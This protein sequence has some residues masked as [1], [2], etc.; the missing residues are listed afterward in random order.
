MGRLFLFGEKHC[1]PHNATS[2][3]AD[4]SVGVMTGEQRTVVEKIQF[5]HSCKTNKMKGD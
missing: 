2:N 4:I 1:K 5:E 3:K